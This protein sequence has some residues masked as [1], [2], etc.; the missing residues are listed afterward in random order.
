MVRTGTP[1]MFACFYFQPVKKRDEVLAGIHRWLTP[2]Y[3]MPNLQ[4]EVFY[5]VE[6]LRVDADALGSTVIT[7][8]EMESSSGSFYRTRLTASRSQNFTARLA[9]SNHDPDPRDDRASPVA[10]L[11]SGDHYE[12]RIIRAVA[13]TDASHFNRFEIGSSRRPALP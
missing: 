7:F 12:V 1:T 2:G 4:L 13:N 10:L 8:R 3:A 11:R 5:E 9:M 6:G